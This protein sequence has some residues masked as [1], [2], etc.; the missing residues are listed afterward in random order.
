MEY[1]NNDW[2]M[3]YFRY[4]DRKG[5]LE[6]AYL[7]QNLI[8]AKQLGMW[9]FEGTCSKQRDTKCEKLGAGTRLIICGSGRKL[10]SWVLVKQAVK[11]DVGKV[12]RG[13]MV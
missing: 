12:L 10:S 13:R 7:F 2:R 5:I 11:D 6:E 8:Y 3:Q 4:R 9:K 1:G